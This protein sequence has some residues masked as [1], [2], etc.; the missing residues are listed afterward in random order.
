MLRLFKIAPLLVFLFL[1]LSTQRTAAQC[2]ERCG[3]GK[4]CKKVCRLIC[5]EKKDEITCWGCGC[6]EF[7][8]PGPSTAKCSKCSCID[9]SCLEGVDN[10]V[11][12]KPKKFVWNEWIPGTA[13]VLTKKKLMKRTTTKTIPSYKWVVEE[14]CTDCEVSFEPLEIDPNPHVPILVQCELER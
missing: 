7:C 14:V 5:E 1:A 11:S 2:C 6:E 4:P 10:K 8:I 9:C 12:S 3:L 13:K